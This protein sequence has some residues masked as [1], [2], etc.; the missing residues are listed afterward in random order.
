MAGYTTQLERRITTSLEKIKKI[1]KKG[2][3]EKPSK[4]PHPL[5]RY[6]PVTTTRSIACGAL[7]ARS[8]T[9]LSTPPPTPVAAATATTATTTTG[10]DKMPK[11][12]LDP[13]RVELPCAPREFDD[14]SQS[15][16]GRFRRRIYQR[17]E[18]LFVREDQRYRCA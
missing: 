4:H 1:A 8:F 2:A 7:R 16:E 6:P 14:R 9:S 11:R 17:S 5:L 3:T 12:A 10:L 13:G 15:S 18:R